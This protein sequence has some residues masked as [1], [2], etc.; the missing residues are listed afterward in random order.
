VAALIVAV[1]IALSLALP[2]V[3]LAGTD[4]QQVQFTF[5]YCSGVR[6]TRDLPV[7][8]SGD[9]Q[10]NRFVT[11]RDISTPSGFSIPHWWWRGNI[12]VTYTQSGRTYFINAFVPAQYDISYAWH[13][14]AD[15]VNM[16]CIG[17]LQF[18]TT[19]IV[20][21]QPPLGLAQCHFDERNM[22]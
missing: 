15:L 1:V 12:H 6:P 3:G 10:H 5:A 7:S 14:N 21:Q 19:R 9:N 8:I 2:T 22:A 17:T 4:G 13:G 16:S 20:D 11:W 18:A